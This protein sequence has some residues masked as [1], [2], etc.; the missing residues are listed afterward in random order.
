MNKNRKVANIILLNSLLSVLTVF[1][2][3]QYVYEESIFFNS[4]PSKTEYFVNEKL[5]LTGLSVSKILEDGSDE[6]ITDYTVEPADGTL[7]DKAGE[8]TIEITY[9]EHKLSFPVKVKE[10]V[11]EK[12]FAVSFPKNIYYINEKLDL[13]GLKM[14]ALKTD[15]TTYEI[16]DYECEPSDGS[17]LSPVKNN[18]QTVK[19][20]YNNLEFDFDVNV[21]SSFLEFYEN[22]VDS[23]FEL[24]S[25]SQNLTPKVAVTIN[26]NLKYIWYRKNSN[27]EIFTK[28]F[29]SEETEVNA[30]T[31]NEV[32]LTLPQNDYITSEYYCEAILS[33]NDVT[34]S[35]YIN[36]YSDTVTIKQVIHTGLPTVKLNTK[37]G[38]DITSKEDYVNASLEINSEDY[39]DL[40]L[41]SIKIKGRG[42]SSWNMPKKSYTLKFSDKSKVL[43]MKKSKKWVLIANYA[44]KTLLRN[45]FASYLGNEIFDNMEW[46]PSFKSV[47]L[48]LNGQYYGTYLFGESIKIEE[49]RVNIQSAA[50]SITG[51]SKYED[52]NGDGVIDINDGG[53]IVEVNQ[54]LDENFNFKTTKGVC[55]S[56]K[57]PDTDDFVEDA[58]TL[59]DDVAT[60][61]KG[62]I[63]TAEDVLYSDD[64][65]D[66]ENGYTK[67]IDVDSF[68]D[69]YLVNEFSSNIDSI[70]WY[71]STYMYFDPYKQ[72]ICLGPNWDFDVAFGNYKEQNENP[73]TGITRKYWISRL[74]NDSKFIYKLK[75]R[76]NEI[77]ELL[78]SSI[79]NEYQNEAD[80]IL[81]SA[82]LNF[83]RWP[84]LGTYVWPNVSD[85]EKRTTF[86]SEIDYIVDWLQKRCNYLDIKINSL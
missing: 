71:S 39:D 86:E 62:K 29:E 48:V 56:L 7:F 44:D 28:I 82:E 54:R 73:S 78:K 77:N 66:P 18:K 84:I 32:S 14:V 33:K 42:N 52:L 6:I 58:T 80:V 35:T 26:G 53:F 79:T 61:I 81:S 12:I 47:D 2:C 65:L 3:K 60:Y 69:W 16:T 50:D 30:G 43:G 49:N 37:D 64:W 31:V 40:S 13:S 27:E 25:D 83:V 17:V 67:Y 45:A 1:S 72:K 41:D 76:W 38:K 20:S 63:Q 70:L 15:G 34:G 19:V 9:K 57:D 24:Y 75:N 46:N 36:K 11:D 5:D 55:I 51:K 59:D 23:E 22:P 68:I 4:L 10:N 8:Y 74:F 21:Y 85:Y